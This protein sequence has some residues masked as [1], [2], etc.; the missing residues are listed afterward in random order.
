MKERK[1]SGLGIQNLSRHT[2]PQRT[3]GGIRHFRDGFRTGKRVF[4]PGVEHHPHA[5]EAEVGCSKV[6]HRRE[7][8][9][10]SGQDDG[11]TER[12]GHYVHHAS[13]KRAQRRKDALTLAAR[14]APC[15]HVEHS[16]SRR[17]SQQ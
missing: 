12:R 9:G 8:H 2:L 11:D 5:E 1:N 4:L 13:Q 15:Q 3:S 10:R 17:D 7:R 14:Q 16:R 6:L